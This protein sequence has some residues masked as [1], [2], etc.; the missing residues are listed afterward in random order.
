MLGS[1]QTAKGET[2]EEES[3]KHAHHFLLYQGDCS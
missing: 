2:G 1:G 3:Q